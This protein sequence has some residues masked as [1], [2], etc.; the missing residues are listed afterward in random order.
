MDWAGENRGTDKDTLVAGALTSGDWETAPTAPQDPFSV[1]VFACLV[2]L[3]AQESVASGA[4]IGETLGLRSADLDALLTIY[5]SSTGVALQAQPSIIEFDEEEEQ[6]RALFDRYRIDDSLETG[7]L[8]SMLARRCMS[9]NHLWQDLGLSTRGDLNRLMRERFPA[10]AARN[11]QN[12]KWKKYF[13]RCLCEMEGFSL[14]AAPTCAECSD[15]SAC[16][17]EETGAG[18]LTPPDALRANDQNSS[19][20]KSRS[21]NLARS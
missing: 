9:P 2:T 11:A 17:G 5:P 20:T 16:F 3:A 8:V 19:P 13:Y 4:T 6:L 10:L 14:C 21:T 15:Y 12:M 1:H 7:W 18:R